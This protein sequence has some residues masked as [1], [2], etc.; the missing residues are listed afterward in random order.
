MPLPR[1]EA[2]A[3][4]GHRL[5]K[6]FQAWQPSPS[7]EEINAAYKFRYILPSARSIILFIYIG[8]L[9]SAPLKPQRFILQ[10]QIA[11]SFSRNAKTISVTLN[12]SMILFS[13]NTPYIS[14]TLNREME[15]NLFWYPCIVNSTYLKITFHMAE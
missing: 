5:L 3:S 15:K 1:Q 13:P 2:S 4:K 10:H 12:S 9:L 7:S 11:I 14:S 6:S 8:I